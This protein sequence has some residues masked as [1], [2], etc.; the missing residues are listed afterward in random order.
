MDSFL[1]NPAI[2][3]ANGIAYTAAMLYE[4]AT[5]IDEMTAEIKKLNVDGIIFDS[6]TRRGKI[7]G[8]KL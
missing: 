5:R 6:A 3:Q 8:L 2:Q 7:I 1:D 4:T